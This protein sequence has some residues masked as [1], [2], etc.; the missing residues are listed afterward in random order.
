M[1]DAPARDVWHRLL[2]EP[3]FLV[4]VGM[5][6]LFGVLMWLNSRRNGPK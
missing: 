4:I 5:G 6:V 3:L 1:N 2:S